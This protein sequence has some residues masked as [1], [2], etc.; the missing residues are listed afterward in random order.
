ML[1]SKL[2]YPLS[3]FADPEKHLCSMEFLSLIFLCSYKFSVAEFLGFF[4]LNTYFEQFRFW[5][6][7][8]FLF[9]FLPFMSLT[10]STC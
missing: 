6:L 10:F 3:H 2:L 7:S 5:R 4:S 9:S 8:P 1:G